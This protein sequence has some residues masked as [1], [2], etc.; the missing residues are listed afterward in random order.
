MEFVEK[1]VWM[2]RPLTYIIR[3]ELTPSATGFLTPAES[4]QQVGFVVYPA[5][6][7]VA[8]HVHR[9]LER[10]ITGTSEALIVKKGRCEVDIYSATKEAVATRELREGDI[11]L[12]VEGG[13]GF[14]MLEDTVFLEIKQGPYQGL[15]EKERF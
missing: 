11:L 6:G 5:G 9:S 2:G 1:I 3:R 14:R 4:P 8:P 12:L 15:D 7:R 13:H 10:Q